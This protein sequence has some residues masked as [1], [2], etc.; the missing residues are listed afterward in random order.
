MPVEYYFQVSVVGNRKA[1]E[2]MSPTQMEIS[3]V[4]GRLGDFASAGYALG[5]HIA[6]T[7]PKFMFQTYPKEWLDYY[8]QNGLLMSDPMVAWGF[9][10]AGVC[11]WSNLDDSAGV[12]KK[13]GEHGMGF[14]FVYATEAGGTRSICGFARDD[15]EFTDEEIGQMTELVEVVHGATADTAKLAPETIQQLKNMSVMVTHPGN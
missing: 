14:G 13:A 15:R 4:L 3:E 11:R 12:M 5:F 8:S 9:E 2:D 1:S 6:Y 7:T 10:N